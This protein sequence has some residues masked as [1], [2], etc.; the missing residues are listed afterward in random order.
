MC[1]SLVVLG[2]R[3][4]KQALVVVSRVA[5][6]GLLLLW[7]VGSRRSGLVL[8]APGLQSTGLVVVMHGF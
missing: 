7:S 4:C 2:L 6:H 3:C 1:L 5:A 8:V